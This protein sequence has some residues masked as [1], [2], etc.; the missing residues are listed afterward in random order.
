MDKINSF[1]GYSCIG[2][3]SLK[4]IQNKIKEKNKNLPKI[5]NLNNIE[6]KMGKIENE[7][8][9]S[10]LNNFLKAYNDKNE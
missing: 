2:E 3:I 4:I 5:K 10:S 7:Q 1:F 6:E 8:L 9:K